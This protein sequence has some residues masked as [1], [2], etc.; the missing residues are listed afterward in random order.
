MTIAWVVY[1]VFAGT[2]IV[3][4][5]RAADSALA[6]SGRST[7]WIWMC[8]LVGLAVMAIVAPRAR[9][10]EIVALDSMPASSVKESVINPPARDRTV[11]E[12]IESARR[13]VAAVVTGAISSANAHVPPDVAKPVAISWAVTS[14]LLLAIYVLVNLQLARARRHWP[15]A[16]MHGV[17]VRVAPR[18]GPAVIGVVRAEI[19]VPRSLLERSEDQQR[20]IVL[21]EHEHLR[22]RDHILLGLGCLVAMALPW[23]PA[24]WYALARL[25]LAIELD[26]DARVLR[27]GA[28]ARS[29]GALLIDMAAHGAGLRGAT[30]ALADRPSHLERRLLAMK[31]KR[32]RF[33]LVRA[34]TLCAVAGLLTMAA[35][36]ARVPTSAELT[37]M[38]VA[39]AEKAAAR[40]GALANA[41]ADYFLNG[42]RK[43]REE[44]MKLDAKVIGSMTVVKSRA[45][46]GR[47]TIFVVTNDMMPGLDGVSRVGIKIRDTGIPNGGLRPPTARGSEASPTI[48]IDGK[49]STEERLAALRGEDIATINITKPDN[50]VTDKAYPNGLL[51]IETKAR[52]AA[53]SR[54]RSAG[55]S[56]VPDRVELVE[57]RSASKT[58]TGTPNGTPS[59]PPSVGDFANTGKSAGPSWSGKAAPAFV[60][61]GVPATRAQF[62]ALGQH[63]IVR[64]DVVKEKA[65]VQ[66][67]SNDPAAVN[68]V[69][70]VTTKRAKN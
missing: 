53:I 27:G 15:L 56:T 49:M 55:V 42:E 7:R 31:A 8:A 38:D 17:R 61:D 16:N 10:V 24:S 45:I 50:G 52:A 63:D 3:L 57:V 25:R 39:A 46:G 6:L 70:Q 32:S 68:G 64:I 33:M 40:A 65:L 44:V 1:L 29:Y 35:C 26:C 19:V 59:V 5:A 43:A 11:S 18:A 67:I 4:G 23:H 9:S 58:A 28:A 54:T 41:D 37:S 14:T 36:E 30:L 22:A 2:L 48:M 12:R 62:E 21:H 69:V 20:L 66:A 13:Q 34:A 47:D 51:W 60:I